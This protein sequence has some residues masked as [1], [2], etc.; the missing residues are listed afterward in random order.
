M[1]PYP[2]DTDSPEGVMD[3]THWLNTGGKGKGRVK[4][5]TKF[6][7]F[8]NRLSGDAFFKT[9]NNKI[10]EKENVWVFFFLN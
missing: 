6:S 5:D 2:H 9:R 4:D 7:S 1:S 3:T 8:G 10:M